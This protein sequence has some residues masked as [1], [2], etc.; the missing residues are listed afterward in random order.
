LRLSAE[1][2]AVMAEWVRTV[3]R[4][5][6]LRFKATG[7]DLVA[8]TS[9]T[10]LALAHLAGRKLPPAAGVDRYQISLE[11]LRIWER[12]LSSMTAE[13][14]RRLPGLEPGRVDTIVPGAVILCSVV[15][16]AGVSQALVCDAA[17]RDGL[18]ADYLAR[19]EAALALATSLARPWPFARAPRPRQRVAPGAA[20]TRRRKL[21]GAQG[22]VSHAQKPRRL[23]PRRVQRILARFA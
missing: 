23:S 7:F 18:I 21:H 3:M 14:R 19:R 9:G 4:P 5:T 1:D 11:A 6:V 16:L 15:E 13:E 2:T 8:L 12:R 20:L 10:A 22:A 17:L